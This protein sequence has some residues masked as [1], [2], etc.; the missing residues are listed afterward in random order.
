MNDFQEH[1]NCERAAMAALSYIGLAL[2]ALVLSA[3]ALLTADW[4]TGMDVVAQVAARV[5]Q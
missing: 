5:S 3:A 2:A 4:W 1:T